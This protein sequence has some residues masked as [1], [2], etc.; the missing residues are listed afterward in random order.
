M[1]NVDLIRR[2]ILG[3]AAAGLT[4]TDVTSLALAQAPAGGA[5]GSTLPDQRAAY[6]RTPFPEQRQPWPAL[7][8]KMTPRPDNGE[9]SYRGSG[10][11]IGREALLTGGDSGI[12]EARKAILSAAPPVQERHRI[13]LD[14]ELAE[15]VEVALV[16]T[17]P[18]FAPC[19][20]RHA[21]PTKRATPRAQPATQ[22]GPR[23]SPPPSIA[24]SGTRR[25]GCTSPS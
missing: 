5:P 20:W 4:A 9:Q 14:A 1:S 17:V 11:L 18:A 24:L 6:T 8:S 16:R 3:G 19:V 22:G 2:N 15:R 7:T 21:S 12:G 23:P 13:H 10:K 25:R